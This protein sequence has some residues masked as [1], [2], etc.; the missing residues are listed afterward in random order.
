MGLSPGL[1]N[2]AGNIHVLE[3]NGRMS[4][5]QSSNLFRPLNCYAC[6]IINS[7]SALEL[8]G[9]RVSPPSFPSLPPTPPQPL[10]RG[11]QKEKKT[12]NL[13]EKSKRRD[14]RLICRK[15]KSRKNAS[16]SLRR[17]GYN[18]PPPFQ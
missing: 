15:C 7:A 14:P 6:I 5:T 10:T 9:P 2:L 17:F 8:K 4:H 11:Q 12:V 1:E 3:K 13:S 16:S 18:P